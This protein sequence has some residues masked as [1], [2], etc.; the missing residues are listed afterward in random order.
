MKKTIIS[1]GVIMALVLVTVM[2]GA[3][4]SVPNET[5]LIGG[6]VTGSNG[7]PIS[8]ALVLAC[9]SYGIEYAFSDDSG[10]YVVNNIPIFED[11]EIL[12]FKEHYKIFRTSVYIDMVGICL[13]LDIEL[14]KKNNNIAENSIIHC[15]TQSVVKIN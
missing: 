9:S 13:L 3:T 14:Q 4:Y 7:K 1:I 10:Q 2:A 8:G 6:R 5:T 15:N 11:I 12:C